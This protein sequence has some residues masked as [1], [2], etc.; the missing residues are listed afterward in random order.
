MIH[1]DPLLPPIEHKRTFMS[2]WSDCNRGTQNHSTRA[3]QVTCTGE[4]NNVH[5]ILVG[6]PEIKRLLGRLKSR[7]EY[8]IKTTVKEMG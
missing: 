5:R 8:N 4:K 6:K 3:G 2:G 7:L 1:P